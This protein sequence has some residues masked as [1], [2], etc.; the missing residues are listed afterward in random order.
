MLSRSIPDLSFTS[1]SNE[2][3]TTSSRP[4]LY[5]SHNTSSANVLTRYTQSV[6]SSITALP[7]PFYLNDVDE[8]EPHAKKNTKNYEDIKSG[9]CEL[10]DNFCSFKEKNGTITKA[11]PTNM[12]DQC[13]LWDTSCSGN[14]TLAM[15]KFFN[16]AFPTGF[17]P[18]DDKSIM[19]N[20]CF[21]Q[22]PW[23]S[24]S[25]CDTYNSPDRLSEWQKIK[26]WMRSPQCV[27]D[28]EEWQNMTGNSWGFIFVGSVNE[29][30]SDANQD[31]VAPGPDIH[32]AVEFA[33]WRPRML[34]STTGLSPM[35]IG[36]V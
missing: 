5:G 4:E 21:V 25:D 35:P 20:D 2:T 28:A 18:Y 3:A 34:T 1:S 22:N 13:V 16:I 26:D 31:R 10:T 17:D 14:T 11:R 32:P 24:Q 6:N 8:V 12:D 23:V 9:F 15:E 33:K 7:V 19:G 27:S 29:S 36:H 30:Y